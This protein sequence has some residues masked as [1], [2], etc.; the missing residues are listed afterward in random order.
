MTAPA[1][2]S[3]ISSVCPCCGGS[4]WKHRRYTQ[5]IWYDECVSC[6]YWLQRRST[7]GQLQEVFLQEQE[8][9]YADG[10]LVASDSFGMLNE[11]LTQRRIRLIDKHLSPMGK[12]IEAGPGSGDV[13][14]ALAV[15][16][17]KCTAVEHSATL[18][19]R[20]KRLGIEQVFNGDF[21]E[22]TLAPEAFDAYCSFHVIEHL[23]DFRQHIK[24][25]HRCV[26]PGGLLILA[27][28]NA[29]GL[30]QNLPFDLQLNSDS[31][32]FQLFSPMSLR[33][34]LRE[35]GFEIIEQT[36]PSYAMAWLR[37]V[38]LIL[39]RLKGHGAQTA[40]GAYARKVGPIL[41][42]GLRLFS[43]LS[44]PLRSVQER[45]ASGNE[46]L[47]VARKTT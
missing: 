21:A 16:G 35:A 43:W 1:D 39:R 12:V 14:L 15:R 28:P 29:T 32:H 20:L 3:P 31:A 30:E 5:E 19:D 18:A 34:I 46:L 17:Y 22:Q 2:P 24:A 8:K 10:S 40:G 47:V 9:F 44:W 23:V 11:E 42:L 7:G 13:L 4:E 45:F 37:V 38:T 25:V 27:T 6:R 26:K 36:T 41:A 33:L